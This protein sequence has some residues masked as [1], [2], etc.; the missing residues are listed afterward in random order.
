MPLI[1]DV[2]RREEVPFEQGQWMEFKRLSWRQLEMAAEIMTDAVIKRLKVL[3]G[4]ILTSLQQTKGEQEA[5]PSQRYDRGFVLEA[6][7]ANWSYEEDIK[8]A[9]PDERKELINRL[10]EKTA[11]WAFE[12][13]LDLNNDRSEAEQKNV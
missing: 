10:D 3:G 7:I 2:A 9:K 4:D 5:D 13:I 11:L 1:T 12:R 8:N 6:G